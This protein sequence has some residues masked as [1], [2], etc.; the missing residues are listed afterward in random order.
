MD[1]N[2]LDTRIFLSLQ[3][4]EAGREKFAATVA[5]WLFSFLKEALPLPTCTCVCVVT[6]CQRGVIYSAPS[7]GP[8]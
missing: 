5:A 8:G 4:R 2:K 3:G 1:S 7:D 6:R